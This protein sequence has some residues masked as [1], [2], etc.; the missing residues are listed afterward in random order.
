M[1]LVNPL[2][3]NP[4]KWPE[5]RSNNCLSVFGHLVGLARLGLRVNV[6]H[7]LS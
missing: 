7:L 1:T 2:S 4:T 5:T 3:A 6:R